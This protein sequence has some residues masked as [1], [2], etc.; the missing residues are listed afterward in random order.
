MVHGLNG[1]SIN[2]WTQRGCFWPRDL[3]P[4]KLPTASV[5]TFGYNAGL[6]M[7]YSTLN[8]QD[9]ATALLSSLRD[10]REEPGVSYF[11]LRV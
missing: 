11:W 6:A 1:D 10:K 3:L 4:E 9:H 5:L 7:N 2:T 8:I